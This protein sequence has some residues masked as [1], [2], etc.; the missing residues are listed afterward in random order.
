MQR[1][2]NYHTVH[3]TIP[4]IRTSDLSNWELKT[5]PK[6]GVRKEIFDK[7]HKKCDVRKD[8]I[9]IV[10]DGT[11]LIGTTAFVTRFD[12]DILFQ[13]HIYRIRVLKPEKISPYLLLALL[14]IPLVK[15][16]IRAKQFTQDII[17]TLGKRILELVLPI[18]KSNQSRENISS[19]VKTIIEQRSELRNQARQIV[20]DIT[21]KKTITEEEKELLE[22]L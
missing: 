13:S 17:D 2:G 4:F 5:D 14:N 6:H 18:P 8:D 10:R 20:I 22:Q 15:K 21:G 7:Y 19:T 11:Y 3:G 16:Q 12:V 1:L 9:L